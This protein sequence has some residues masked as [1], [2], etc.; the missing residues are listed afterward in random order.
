MRRTQ[1]FDV[2]GWQQDDHRPGTCTAAVSPT[3]SGFPNH[4]AMN[5]GPL[6]NPSNRI[7]LIPGHTH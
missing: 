3:T 7:L 2:I 4:P 6:M 1:S 5:G